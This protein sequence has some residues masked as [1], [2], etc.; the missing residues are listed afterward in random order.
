LVS[1]FGLLR[2]DESGF[3]EVISG[4]G[5]QKSPRLVDEGLRGCK[6]ND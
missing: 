3:P 5:K 6:W 2:Q 4:S 1:G